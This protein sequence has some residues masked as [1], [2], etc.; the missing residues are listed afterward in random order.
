MVQ[1]A[2]RECASDSTTLAYAA[3]PVLPTA[4]ATDAVTLVAALERTARTATTTK[5][6]TYVDATARC[7]AFESYAELLAAG[8]RALIALR[9]RIS[10]EEG[11]AL[12][13]QISERRIHFH[14]FW[15]C[16]LGGIV[17]VTI[18]I[19]PRYDA[20]NAVVLKVQSTVAQLD[21]RHVMASAANVEPLRGLLPAAVTVHGVNTLAWDATD[22]SAVE[23]AITPEHVAFYQLTSGSTG[24][25]KVI[26]ERHCAIIAHI[27]HSAMHCDYSPNDV[28]LNWLPFDHVVP[29]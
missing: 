9:A 6:I 28:T 21:A 4:G 19:P 15:G 22:E 10:I 18:A 25:P 26:P 12:V 13:L 17:P 24:T 29:M 5:G 8:R 2:R 1:P 20:G 27:R 16:L 11:G 7:A 23:A 14:I 3:G